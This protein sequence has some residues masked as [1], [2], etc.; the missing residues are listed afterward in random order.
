MSAPAV[1]IQA[2][3]SRNPTLPD[4]T[5]P[6]ARYWRGFKT[7][8]L[9]K[10]HNAIT[11]IHFS[12]TAP[13]DFAV[14]SSTR[15]QIFSAKTRQVART[16]A[17]FKDNVYSAEY[18]ADGRLLAAGDASGLI[19]LF[20]ANSRAL[21]VSLKPTAHP[22]HVTTFHPQ[23]LTSMLSA[24]DDGVVRLWDIT[25]STPVAQFASHNDYVRTAAFV[26][27]SDLIVSGCYDSKV[28]LFDTR[29]DGSDA[30]S[31][32]FDQDD[33]VES[34]LPL[35]STTIATAGGPKVRIWDL[36]AGRMVAELSNFQ[37]TVTSLA[38]GYGRGLL[39]GSLDGHV[40]VFDSA[41]TNWN[42]QFGWKF[43]GAVLSTALSP[44]HKHFVAG[45]TSGLFTIRTRKT[46][47]KVAQGV[48]QD[49]SG[50]F[51]RMIRGAEYLGHA[52]HKVIN[53]TPKPTKK[54]KAY[55]RHMNAFRW[56]DALDSAFAPGTPP[57]TTLTVLAELRKRGKIAVALAGR[58]EDSL[59]PLLSWATKAVNDSR[60]VNEVADWVGNVIDIYGSMIDRSAILEVLVDE[61]ERQV[62]RQVGLAKD[63]QRLE[64]MLEMLMA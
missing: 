7:P 4:Q 50:N 34:V 63:S 49:K 28:R 36:T 54:L 41:S 64:G 3:A 40:K 13:H 19:Q 43:G 5:T 26:P 42:V 17:R 29:T 52:E 23:K 60:A 27:S 48:K 39:A 59:E 47:P 35:N 38:S 15:V 30:P 51:A 1:R 14:T 6:E 10:E 57:E 62:D 20:D 21:L 25:D 44:D 24:S 18:R 37:K 45:L 11:Q 16:I 2:S 8:V 58:D 22:T 53:D 32:I 31:F 9:V 12:P 46:A 55:E 33:P 61:L 56:G